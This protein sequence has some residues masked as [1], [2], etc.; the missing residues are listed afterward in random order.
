[1]SNFGTILFLFFVLP[2]M[3]GYLIS[4]VEV[5]HNPS[6]ENIQKHVQ[7]TVEESIP[8][9]IKPVQWL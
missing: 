8:W 9:Y 5:V 6:S 1:M 7:L 2:G 3:A 4:T